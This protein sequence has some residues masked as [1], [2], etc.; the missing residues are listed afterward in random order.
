MKMSPKIIYAPGVLKDLKKL[1]K[2]LSKRIVEKIMD[3]VEMDDPLNRAKALTGILSGLYRY[4]VGEWRVIFF[5][6]QD[7]VFEIVKILS[8]KHRSQVY[9]L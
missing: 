6:D 5:L 8:V 9:K 3:N 4:R 2:T 1:D 7:G